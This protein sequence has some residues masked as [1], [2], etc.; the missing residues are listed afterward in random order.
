MIFMS[1]EASVDVTR[2]GRQLR[3]KIGLALTL[4]GVIPLLVL[5]YIVHKFV[6]P[7][8]PAGDTATAVPLL[9]L[10]FFS[11]LAMV[12]GG[13]VIWDVGQAVEQMAELL[14]QQRAIAGVEHRRDEVGTLLTSFNHMLETI[15][16]QAHE[17]TSFAVRLDSAYKELE[18]TNARLK[19]TSFKDDVTDLYNRRFFTVRLEEELARYRRFQHPLAIVLLDLDGFKQIN[20]ELGHAAGD[21]TLR[22]VAQLLVTNSRGVTAR[23]GG[24][25]FAILLVETSAA[26][27]CAYAERMRRLLSEHVFAHG[28]P[29]TASF[30]VSSLP[31]ESTASVA[32]LLR[33]ADD[34]LYAAKRAGKNQVTGMVSDM[35]T[36]P[37]TTPEQ[38]G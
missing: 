34:A 21:V 37:A 8:L 20:D 27:A 15:E 22:E 12:A 35:G 26:G 10:V 19:E 24:D 1:R 6:L 7:G 30:G 9:S 32:G 18:R 2:A 16:Q 14:G 36:I 17:L 5:A 25:E 13:Y 23:Y 11:G 33:S 4:S 28:L 29:I 38:V 3:R 31:E